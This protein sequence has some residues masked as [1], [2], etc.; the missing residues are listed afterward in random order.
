MC[1][2]VIGSLLMRRGARDDQIPDSGATRHRASQRLLRYASEILEAHGHEFAPS[3]QDHECALRMLRV[4]PGQKGW[5]I[6]ADAILGGIAEMGENGAKFDLAVV[7]RD[8]MAFAGIGAEKRR[9]LMAL[10]P[11]CV[12]K[13]EARHSMEV[14]LAST[15]HG[16]LPYSALAVAGDFPREWLKFSE[17][18]GNSIGALPDPHVPFIGEEAPPEPRSIDDQV[19]AEGWK[20]IVEVLA[21]L[22]QQKRSVREA[23]RRLKSM[24]IVPTGRPVKLLKSHVTIIRQKLGRDAE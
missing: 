8:L 14:M 10:W 20:V 13:G 1:P 11:Q 22:M 18:P 15:Y 9:E 17:L 16:N 19:V 23:A 5:P 6:A 21:P 4:R 2:L 7:E 12:R 3:T 24:G